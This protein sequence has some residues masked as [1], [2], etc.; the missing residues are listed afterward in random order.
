MVNVIDVKRE[1]LWDVLRESVSP[2]ENYYGQGEQQD[3]FE[4]LGVNLGFLCHHYLPD[5]KGVWCMVV[6]FMGG[7]PCPDVFSSTISSTRWSIS[8]FWA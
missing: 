7:P 8:C 3:Y 5:H 2:G 1:L 6:N 4:D